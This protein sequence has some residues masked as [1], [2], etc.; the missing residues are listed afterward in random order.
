MYAQ[1]RDSLPR[2]LSR[3]VMHFEA[4]LEDSVQEFAAQ[5]SQGAM[6]LDAGAGEARHRKAFHRQRY[7]GVDLAVGD[8]QWDYSGIEAL[9]DLEA[10]PFRNDSF[11]GAINIVT[12]EHV[13]HPDRVLAEIARVLKPQ[14][15][16]L[17][18]VPQDWEVHQSPH[19]YFRYT[20]HG[21]AYLLEG[22]GFEVEK[23]QPVGGIFRVIA[24]RLFGT[25]QIAWWLAPLTIPL[26]LFLP[27]FDGIDQQKNAT[28]GYLA[29]ARVRSANK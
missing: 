5:L 16:L 26:A 21:L 27:L 12:L 17:I 7:F 3:Y 22:A 15:K 28:P 25:L 19:D 29:V 13:R 20:R 4:T 24:R 11:D 14:G 9:A 6:V 1:L 10:L 18:I 2:W 8:S 23:L